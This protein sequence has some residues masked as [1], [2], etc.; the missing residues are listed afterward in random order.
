VH[1][2][3]IREVAAA[4]AGPVLKEYISV[5]SATRPYFR[6]DK[7]APISEFVAEAAF[8]PVLELTP[9]R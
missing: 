6:A 4:E 3:A 7:T 1:T 5:A 2:Y 9:I 8:H